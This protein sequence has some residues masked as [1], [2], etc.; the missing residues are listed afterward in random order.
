MLVI[1]KTLTNVTFIGNDQQVRTETRIKG[2]THM[3]VIKH[4]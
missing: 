2:S 3:Q 4:V 1:A